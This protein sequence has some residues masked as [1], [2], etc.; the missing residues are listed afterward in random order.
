[1]IVSLRAEGD[2]WLP[3]KLVW[4]GHLLF[5]IGFLWLLFRKGA[6]LK[7]FHYGSNGLSSVT[8]A[9]FT[10]DHWWILLLVQKV[11]LHQFVQHISRLLALGAEISL[12]QFSLD[13][14]SFIWSYKWWSKYS[15]ILLVT[16]VWYSEIKVRLCSQVLGHGFDSLKLVLVFEW[17]DSIVHSIKFL[18]LV[19]NSLSNR[20][21]QIR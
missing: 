10:D 11:V 6:S 16:L 8:L 9:V 3:S 15:Q 5:A 12:G 13:Y 1:M 2:W 19:E 14:L 18:V 21:V 7:I 4:E 17:I 20:W